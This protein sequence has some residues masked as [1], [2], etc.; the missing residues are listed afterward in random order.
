VIPPAS[1]DVLRAAGR[2]LKVNGEAVYGAMPTPFGEELGEPSAK[3]TKDLRGQPL[4]LVR[5]EYRVTAKPG[6][7]YFTFFIEPRVPFELPAMKNAVKR[8]YI[9]GNGAPLTLAAKD[10]R[11][12][13]TLPRPILDPMG[14]VVVVEFEGEKVER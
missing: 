14:T 11:T 5:D 7:L 4:F 6:K 8:A 9:L 12:S 2:W 10:G 13:F 3:G 1:Q